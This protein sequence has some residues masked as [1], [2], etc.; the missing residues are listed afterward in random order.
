MMTSPGGVIAGRH[1]PRAPSYPGLPYSWGLRSIGHQKDK[2]Y[3]YLFNLLLISILQSLLSKPNLAKVLKRLTWQLTLKAL[4]YWNIKSLESERKLFW[5]KVGAHVMTS[6]GY[7]SIGLIIS[8]CNVRITFRLDYTPNGRPCR[9]V[10]SDPYIILLEG[11]G[12]PLAS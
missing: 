1:L 11:L 8:Q 10:L 4:K 3:S 7:S 9:R 12:R 6:M 5:T 2:H